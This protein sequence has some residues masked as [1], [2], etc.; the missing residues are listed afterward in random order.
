MLIP[1][2]LDEKDAN[3]SLDPCA[4]QPLNVRW[5]LLLRIIATPSSWIPSSFPEN[6]TSSPDRSFFC[7]DCIQWV[8]LTP[9]MSSLYR[10]ISLVAWTHF[11]CLIQGADVPRRNSERPGWW[12][13]CPVR[14]V[15]SA[16]PSGHH[17]LW[18]TVRI[19]I[20][21]QGRKKRLTICSCFCN[22]AFFTGWGC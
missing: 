1:L 14:K 21:T 16:F 3:R 2:L 6:K 8:S 22:R 10:C 20:L 13:R 9:S 19:S 17:K 4:S 18:R 15:L 5:T 12:W 7:P 11:S